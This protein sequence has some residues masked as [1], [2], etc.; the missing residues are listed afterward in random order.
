MIRKQ[1]KTEGLNF[2]DSDD[3][4]IELKKRKEEDLRGRN[5]QERI[6]EAIKNPEIKNKLLNE[7]VK[8]VS[9]A[10]KNGSAITTERLLEIAVGSMRESVTK[11]KVVKTADDGVEQVTKLINQFQSRGTEGSDFFSYDFEIN[12]YPLASRQKACNQQFL[13]GIQH[14]TNCSISLRGVYV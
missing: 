10:I 8:A 3:D 9:E 1:M 12:D 4:D 6:A 5:Q 13:H 2:S 7:A 14:S 11:H